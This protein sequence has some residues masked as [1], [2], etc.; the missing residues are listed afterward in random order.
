MSGNNSRD[1]Y[2]EDFEVGQVLKN[3]LGRTITDTDNIW[4][5][6]LTCNT[7]PAH[8]NKD[9]CEKNFSAAPFNG[10][11]IVNAG[12][13]L[14]IV[15][16]LSVENTS[17]HGIMLGMNEMKVTA[18]VFAGDTLYSES[19]VLAKRESRSHPTMGIITIKTRGIKQD[20]STVIEFERT[21]MIRKGGQSW[22]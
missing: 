11:L 8:F 5:T 15:A 20:G 18:P 6:L 2:Y 10:R 3:P 7:N 4:Y 1:R 13:I 14:G 9:Y 17:K 22:K 21:F 12:L 16:G 19:N